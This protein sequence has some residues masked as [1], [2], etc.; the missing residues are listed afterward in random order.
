MAALATL[1][2]LLQCRYNA[3]QD[4]THP[5]NIA[6]FC[7]TRLVY[8]TDQQKSGTLSRERDGL[9]NCSAREPRLLQASPDQ[10]LC[11]STGHRAS[12]RGP[13]QREHYD[14]KERSSTYPWNA[15]PVPGSR[16]SALT[17]GGG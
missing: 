9:V 13:V 10:A 3:I 6:D 14:S 15:A 12:G 4:H 17:S 7:S 5:V 2:T 8:E 16:S 11:L 1:D